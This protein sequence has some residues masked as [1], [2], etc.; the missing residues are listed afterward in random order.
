[1]TATPTTPAG[2]KVIITGA[3]TT[4]S[5]ILVDAEAGLCRGGGIANVKAVWPGHK[6]ATVRMFE[7]A[8]VEVCAG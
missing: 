3:G 7:L 4:I 5:G 1:M 6:R 8:D 2:T